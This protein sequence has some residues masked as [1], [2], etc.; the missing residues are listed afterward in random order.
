M[1][2]S[3]DFRQGII[4]VGLDVGDMNGLAVGDRPPCHSRPSGRDQGVLHRV[5]HRRIDAIDRSVIVGLPLGRTIAAMSASH[6][7]AADLTREFEHRLQVE[8]GTA[9]DFQNVSRCR[10]ALARLV[11]FARQACNLPL[12]SGE[13]RDVRDG[14]KDEDGG[15]DDQPGCDMH[16]VTAGREVDA[17]RASERPP[18]LRLT[19]SRNSRQPA[20][21]LPGGTGISGGGRPAMFSA[22]NELPGPFPRQALANHARS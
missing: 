5:A 19:R 10:V 2:P 9:E 20:S 13:P 16:G 22:K 4:G 7:R 8:R 3:L 17:K 21:S 6:S 15:E 12:R 1:G 14:D 18:A 11:Q